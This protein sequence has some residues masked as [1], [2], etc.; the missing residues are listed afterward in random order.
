MAEGDELL[1]LLLRHS[2]KALPATGVKYAGRDLKNMLDARKWNWIPGRRRGVKVPNP[3]KYLIKLPWFRGWICKATKK[4][5]GTQYSARAHTQHHER[6]KDHTSK[7]FARRAKRVSSGIVVLDD[8]CAEQKRGLRT[9][10]HLKGEKIDPR[11]VYIPNPG[12]RQCAA[13]RGVRA[14]AAQKTLEDAFGSEWEYVGTGAAY[15]DTCSG[16]WRYVADLIDAVLRNSNK[17]YVLAFTILGRGVRRADKVKD[18]T[19]SEESAS[20]P[21]SACLVGRLSSLDSHVRNYGFCKIGKSDLDAVHP[22]DGGSQAVTV[23]YERGM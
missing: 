4:K 22:Y 16:S 3:G 2:R 1:S 11:R 18:V 5:I 12:S 9:L 10:A 23:I 15:L 8:F 14:H 13:A 7:L 21:A 17:R 19:A 6:F 20:G